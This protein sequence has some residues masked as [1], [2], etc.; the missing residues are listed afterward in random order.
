MLPRDEIGT[1]DSAIRILGKKKGRGLASSIFITQHALSRK[2]TW[3]SGEL[4][5]LGIEFEL[6]YLDNWH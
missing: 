4:L 1:A 6:D 3:L 5:N 2:L